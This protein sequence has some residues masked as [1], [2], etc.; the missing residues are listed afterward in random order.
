MA[1]TGFGMLGHAILDFGML[2]EH[3]PEIIDLERHQ[4][5]F[6]KQRHVVD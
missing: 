6:Q 1:A 2:V 4:R 5:G 3:P